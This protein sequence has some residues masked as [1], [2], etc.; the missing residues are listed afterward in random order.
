MTR[1]VVGVRTFSSEA[2][3]WSRKATETDGRRNKQTNK[4]ANKRL[5][6]RPAARRRCG[7]FENARLNG[8][9]LRQVSAAVGRWFDRPQQ[10]W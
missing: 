6:D 5:A 9:R 7:S 2:T 10:T 3:D 8:L 4:Q 1:F